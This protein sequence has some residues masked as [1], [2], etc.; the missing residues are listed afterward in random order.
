MSLY[1]PA[2]ERQKKMF[3]LLLLEQWP[4]TFAYRIPLKFHYFVLS[5]LAALLVAVVTISH[6]TL[7]SARANP[8]KALKYE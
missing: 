5:G 2:I 7:R 8:V 3:T 1:T 6:H 4:Q